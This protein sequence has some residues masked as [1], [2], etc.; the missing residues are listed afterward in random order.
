MEASIS[1]YPETLKPLNLKINMLV[2]FESLHPSHLFLAFIK[3]APSTFLSTFK[4][5]APT[6]RTTIAVYT[7]LSDPFQK[8]PYT[9][10]GPL[11]RV[12]SWCQ[13][14]Q[15][16]EHGSNLIVNMMPSIYIPVLITELPDISHVT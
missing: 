5:C 2:S 16:V 9:H 12:L 14:I 3:I 7:L 13:V 4:V 1:M 15:V 11:L 8:I 6:F 10:F